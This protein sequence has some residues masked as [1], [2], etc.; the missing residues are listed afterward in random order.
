MRLWIGPR[1]PFT[2]VRVGTSIGGR[3]SGMGCLGLF[4]FIVVM[5][6]IIA[7][8]AVA[9]AHPV[10]AWLI[11]GGLVGAIVLWLLNRRPMSSEKP[12]GQA[13]VSDRR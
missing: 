13:S 11:I 6:P 8:C 10:A 1:I 3:G 12:P 9:D 4:V 5:Q 2:P 7:L